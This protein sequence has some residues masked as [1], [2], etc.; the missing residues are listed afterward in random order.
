MW[1]LNADRRSV[2]MQFGLPVQGTPE[3][4][5]VKIDFDAGAIEQI[6][7][8]LTVLRAQMLP[9]QPTPGKMT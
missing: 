9:A 3:P 8:R 7:E 5:M 2:Q 1:Q 4:L 6:I